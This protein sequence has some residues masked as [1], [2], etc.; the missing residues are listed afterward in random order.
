MIVCD[1]AG[2]AKTWNGSVAAS[3]GGSPPSGARQS[4]FYNDRLF[5]FG[6]SNP[7]LLYYSTAGNIETGYASNFI[8]CDANDGEKIV[9]VGKMFVPGELQPVLIVG[10]ERSVGI[11]T[12]DG[13]AG[14][15]FTFSKI[16]YEVGVPGFRQM[17]SF[18]G[19]LA[20][21]TPRGVSS[22]NTAIKGINI[23]QNFLSRNIYDQFTDLTNAALG[24]GLAF[25]DWKRRRMGFALPVDNATYP[26]RIYWFDYQSGCWYYQNG[27][28]VTS[29]F[30]D[31][32]GTLY[33]GTDTGII[34]KHDTT[35]Y[36]Y[37]STAINAVLTTP[38]LDFFEPD[39]YKRIKWASVTARGN[40]SYSVGVSTKR[41]FGTSIG[42]TH[43]VDLSNT[44]YTW[45]GGTWTSNSATYQWGGAP[46]LR[47]YFY[48]KG[49][50]KNIQFTFTQSGTSQPV[51]LFELDFE[52][53]YLTSY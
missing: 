39:G 30:V 46:I 23:E 53:E 13:T 49:V 8:T 50:F 47:K 18:E 11:V 41:D 40:G 17:V 14:D 51:D 15:P 42:S 5:I 43:S 36:H 32:D 52:V 44:A 27:F 33:T 20:F 6:S 3:L 7:S 1:G 21:L 4:I 28:R 31:T 34:Y 9:S 16:N 22:Y 37:A 2:A 38:Y 24:N 35:V 19:D 25:N 10:K 29:A 48:P 12:G 45:N 26:D